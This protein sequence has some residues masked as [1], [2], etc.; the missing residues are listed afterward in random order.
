[1]ARRIGWFFP[2]NG[3]WRE[4]RRAF[5]FW[6]RMTGSPSIS[7]TRTRVP[8]MTPKSL[9]SLKSIVL[10]AILT[11]AGA[12][13]GGWA[14]WAWT[15]PAAA[16]AEAAAAETAA[17][18][19]LVKSLQDELAAA[20]AAIDALEQERRTAANSPATTEPAVAATEG[21]AD[22]NTIFQQAR[23]LLQSL[24][25]MLDTMRRQGTKATADARIAEYSQK[26][27][28]SEDQQE[29]IRKWFDEKSE[30]EA[31]KG[32]GVI[33]N[34]G[35]TLQDMIAA[36]RGQRPDD[37]LDDM[38]ATVL[39][40]EQHAAYHTDRLQERAG[41]VEKEANR[42]V[43]RLD[44]LV[45]LDEAQ[46]DQVFAIMARSSADYDPAMQFEGLGSDAGVL[47]DGTSRDEAILAVLRPDQREAWEADRRRRREAAAR[48]FEAMGL[49]APDNLGIFERLGR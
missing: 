8:A 5:G 32:R 35:S 2:G 29:A 31:E 9:K 39:N 1:M 3:L 11:M 22:L 13:L 45:G 16:Q 42:R 28:L 21:P 46:Q 47:S 36:G 27:G 23:P 12:G 49:K 34:P 10:P 43:S 40:P 25:P 26:Y 48:N 15:R 14:T 44:G 38:M 6:P 20:R 30:K 7:E 41:N 24:G 37:G 19:A 17:S 18:N 33:N 4:G